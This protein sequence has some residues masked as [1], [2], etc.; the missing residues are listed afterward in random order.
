MTE[1]SSFDAIHTLSKSTR[2]SHPNIFH[3]PSFVDTE[4]YR[5]ISQ[6]TSRFTV[7]FSGRGDWTKGIGT[8][9]EI[10]QLLPADCY[11]FETV[12]TA[13]K[14]RPVHDMG[15]M[16]GEDL[17][18]AYSEAHC[19]VH[20]S[21]AD[22][23]P[24]SILE[25]LACGTPVITTPLSSHQRLRLPLIYAQTVTQMAHQLNILRELWMHRP[26]D[27]AKL[28][29]NARIAAVAYDVNT[30]G[31]MYEKMLESVRRSQL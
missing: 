23:C 27:Y 5:P 30:I 26:D 1:F 4:M 29:R 20:P 3:I 8:F 14:T 18:R 11:R 9:I 17:V 12:G 2:I 28:S 6:K 25:S 16:S 15:F 7:L 13:A 21:R 19:L 24:L 31:P 22:V 10:A